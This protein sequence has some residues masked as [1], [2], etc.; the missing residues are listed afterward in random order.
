MESVVDDSVNNMNVETKAWGDRSR[1][2]E[3]NI[4][5]MSSTNVS[6][7]DNID[8]SNTS[9]IEQI[10]DLNSDVNLWGVRDNS[11]IEAVNNVVE[12][13]QKLSEHV[14]RLHWEPSAVSN[15][16]SKVN[17]WGAQVSR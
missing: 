2:V 12:N 8:S 17:S 5:S 14:K 15:V 16:L 3:V 1:A 6:V 7:R 11:A 10:E 4:Q 13:V 9:I